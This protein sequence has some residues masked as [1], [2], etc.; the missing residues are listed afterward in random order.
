MTRLLYAAY[1]LAVLA[2]AL[3]ATWTVNLLPIADPITA[4][5]TDVAAGCFAG[6]AATTWLPA[7]RRKEQP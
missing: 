5:A 3:A 6:L 1:V 2:I 4:W 7:P